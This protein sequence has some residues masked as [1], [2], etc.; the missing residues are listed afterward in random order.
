M[1][2]KRLITNLVKH[3]TTHNRKNSLWMAGDDYSGLSAVQ[4]GLEVAHLHLSC[5][6]VSSFFDHVSYGDTAMLNSLV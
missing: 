3:V 4:I 5:P 2:D 1:S 6:A